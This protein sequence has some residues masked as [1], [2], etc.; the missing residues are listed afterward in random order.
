MVPC[1]S[2]SIVNAAPRG[3]D[4]DLDRAGVGNENAYPG[5]NRPKGRA[6]GSSFGNR[7]IPKLALG[8]PGFASPP[9]DGFAFIDIAPEERRKDANQGVQF[10]QAPDVSSHLL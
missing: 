7:T 3:G 8:I 9:Y 6:G 10:A 4:C 1:A 5:W 2:R